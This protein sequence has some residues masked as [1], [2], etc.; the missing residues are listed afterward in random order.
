M[1]RFVHKIQ[2]QEF[3]RQ[4]LSWYKF[5][6]CFLWTPPS[7]PMTPGLIGHDLLKE[8]QEN[9]VSEVCG[10]QRHLTLTI[11]TW[12]T[13][14]K[15]MIVKLDH[16]NHF[17]R[18]ENKNVFLAKEWLIEALLEFQPRIPNP[19]PT[20]QSFNLSQKSQQLWTQ[21]KSRCLC[22]SEKKHLS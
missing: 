12:T 20:I 5:S 14:L 1:T 2:V 17:P 3:P 9:S 21:K 7:E 15:N 22:P 18:G 4:W 11:L 13:Q 6:V 8:K 16:F 19:R 10:S